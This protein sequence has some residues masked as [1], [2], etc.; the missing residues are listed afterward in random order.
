MCDG[1]ANIFARVSG[2]Y[3]DYAVKFYGRERH[4]EISGMAVWFA[5]IDV[6]TFIMGSF[7]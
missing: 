7:A 5:K 2:A 1:F 6:R 3:L 4:A